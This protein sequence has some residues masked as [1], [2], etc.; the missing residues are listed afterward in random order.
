MISNNNFIDASKND[1]DGD[2]DHIYYFNYG[3]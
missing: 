2:I 3:Q 1:G